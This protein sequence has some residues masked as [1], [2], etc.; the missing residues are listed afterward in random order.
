MNLR[1]ASGHPP[2]DKQVLSS[3]STAVLR[4]KLDAQSQIAD[5]S[6]MPDGTYS[7]HLAYWQTEVHR[8][9]TGHA[10]LLDLLTATR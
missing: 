1:R 9:E 8:L 5:L 2:P 10:W 3:L 4:A 7:D 6:E